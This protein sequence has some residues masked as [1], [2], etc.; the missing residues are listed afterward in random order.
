VS[1]RRLVLFDIDGTLLR[2]AGPHHKQA[3][4]EAARAVLKVDCTLDGVD[5][6]GC[7]DTDLIRIMLA[8]AGVPHLRIS[9]H[10]KRVME[11]AQHHYTIHCKADFTSKVC[12]GVRNA[13]Q[14]LAENAVPVGLVTGN[15]S[16]IAWRKL[17]NAGIEKFFTFGAFAEE[18]KSRSRLAK[19]AALKAKRKGLASHRCS[20]TLIGDHANDIQAAQANGFRAVAVATGM[21]NFDQLSEYKPDLVLNTL[22]GLSIASI[23]GTSK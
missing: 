3:L 6:A 7:L 18:A 20:I 23:C 14:M 12:P 5:T 11:E 21:L 4:T 9:A 2:G 8:N 17:A 1:S 13:L 10:I 15:L 19:L 16:A 22:E